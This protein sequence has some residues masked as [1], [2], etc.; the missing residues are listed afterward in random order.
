[1]FFNSLLEEF[2]IHCQLKNLSLRTVETYRSTIGNVL[3]YLEVEKGITELEQVRRV[4]F[5]DY[6]FYMLKSGKLPT[7]IN[8]INKSLRSFFNYLVA[9]DYCKVNIPKQL[10]TLKEQKQLLTTFNSSEVK[11]M[12]NFYK[13][14]TFLDARNQAILALLFD[15]G[16]RCSELLSIK[17]AHIESNFIRVLGKGNKWRIVPLSLYL[18]K[19]FIKYE[20]EK[21]RYVK[22]LKKDESEVEEYYFL[23]KSLTKMESTVMIEYIVKNCAVAVGVREEVRASPHT[24]RHFYAITALKNGMDIYSISKILG[25]SNLNTTRVYLESIT[26]EEVI[27]LTIS[28]SP[29][30]NL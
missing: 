9:E 16:L 5:Q 24:C 21:E 29:L 7:Y 3:T 18:R 1:M 23:T 30:M 22:K 4:D 2:L 6:N 14:R 15:T 17:N 19:V 10:P 12:L 8:A 11:R 13:R 28:K 20:R 27:K 26:N 25:H